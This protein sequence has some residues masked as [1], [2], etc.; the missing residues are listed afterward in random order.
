MFPADV[1]T[2]ASKA[3]TSLMLAMKVFLSFSVIRAA[4]GFTVLNL[5][6]R[7]RIFK[8]WV[9]HCLMQYKRQLFPASSLK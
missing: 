5:D 4:F 9:A 8:I 1:T 7:F 6:F 2:A 3:I